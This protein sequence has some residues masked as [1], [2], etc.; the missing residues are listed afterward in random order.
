MHR[1]RKTGMWVGRSGSGNRD[2]GDSFR[3]CY[4]AM[5]GG[6]M[7]GLVRTVVIGL[8]NVLLL[9]NG[10]YPC[11]SESAVRTRMM[12]IK[13][14]PWSRNEAYHL[15]DNNSACPFTGAKRDFTGKKERNSEPPE[16]QLMNFYPPFPTCVHL[17]HHC[18]HRHHNQVFRHPAPG[19]PHRLHTFQI[20]LWSKALLCEILPPASPRP[21]TGLLYDQPANCCCMV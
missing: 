17:S 15:P 4:L 14:L 13:A 18:H 3:K 9:S 10:R 20:Y 1:H 12:F 6:Y 2:D 5:E 11:V 19:F 16:R 21:S 7:L 8:A